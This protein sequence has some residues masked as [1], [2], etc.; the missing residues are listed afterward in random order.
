MA[1]VRV[2]VLGF[3]IASK[4]ANYFMMRNLAPGDL[5]KK[6]PGSLQSRLARMLHHECD[7]LEGYLFW[8][9]LIVLKCFAHVQTHFQPS[10]GIFTVAH[11]QKRTRV[12]EPSKEPF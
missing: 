12:G 11:M 1:I 10:S 9:G 6:G 8:G 5:V 4:I 2:I 7:A 3:G